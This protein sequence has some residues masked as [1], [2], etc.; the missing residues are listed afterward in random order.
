MLR[1]RCCGTHLRLGRL[2]LCI[3]RRLELRRALLALGSC[4]RLFL[5]RR[6]A[7]TQQRKRQLPKEPALPAAR[8]GFIRRRARNQRLLVVAA[9][10]RRLVAAARLALATL[11]GRAR[12]QLPRTE[13]GTG[14]ID[15][16]AP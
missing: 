2:L 10:A 11:A 14:R 8:A 16:R 3:R 6:T 9:A 7:R 15:P 5:R 12:V 4:L 1:R 13:R